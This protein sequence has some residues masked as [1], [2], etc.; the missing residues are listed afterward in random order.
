MERGAT[1]P[2]ARRRSTLGRPLFLRHGRRRYAP[3][4]ATR[5]WVVAGKLFL[6]EA[7][8]GLAAA[9]DALQPSGAHEP[10]ELMSRLTASLA[11]GAVGDAPAAVATPVDEP[12]F[13]ALMVNK[14][15]RDFA[16]GDE[17]LL[18]AF[19][20][21]GHIRGCIYMSLVVTPRA[22][23]GDAVGG[24]HARGTGRP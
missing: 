19:Q 13:V 22:R 15:V 6:G 21:R 4:D 7:H 10:S 17:A 14:T 2:V 5:A 16:N 11:V 1:L 12:T 9:V 18:P 8:A 23:G 20:V 3:M 24:L